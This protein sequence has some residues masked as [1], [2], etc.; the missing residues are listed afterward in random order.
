MPAKGPGHPTNIRVRKD[1]LDQTN[2]A[3]LRL[4]M[5]RYMEDQATYILGRVM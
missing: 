2:I 1:V 5:G 3:K 4:N